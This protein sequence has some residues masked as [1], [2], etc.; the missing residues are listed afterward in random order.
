MRRRRLQEDVEVIREQVSAINSALIVREPGTARSVDAY[1]GL[2]RQ[3]AQASSDRRTHLVELVRLTEAIEGGLP[4]DKLGE[5][6]ASW[7]EQAGLVRVTDGSHRELFEVLGGE[8]SDAE[9]EVLNP[10][11]VA[12]EPPMLVRPGLARRKPAT[13]DQ[14]RDGRVDGEG[15]PASDD[16]R[17]EA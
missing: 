13:P 14:V 12:G 11:W 16:E 9:L 4:T 1:D 6:V 5:L 10:A 15:Q 2:R 17:G 3:V 8:D 7:T